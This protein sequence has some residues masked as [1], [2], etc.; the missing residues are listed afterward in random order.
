MS[1]P[2]GVLETLEEDADAE[3]RSEDSDEDLVHVQAKFH[4]TRINLPGFFHTN[5]WISTQ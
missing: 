5:H 2:R 3:E 4:T 1:G